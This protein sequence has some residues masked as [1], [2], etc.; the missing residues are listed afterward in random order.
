[1]PPLPDSSVPPLFFFNAAEERI[2]EPLATQI[3]LLVSSLS[4]VIAQQAGPQLLEVASRLSALCLDS[5]RDGSDHRAEA[6][7]LISEL[8]LES[9]NTL[10]RSFT[11][12]FHLI[13]Q[14]EKQEIVRINR[15]RARESTLDAP[16]SESIEEAVRHLKSEG[17]S[18]P[19]VEELLARI[20]IQP[21]FTAHPTEARRRSILFKQQA[22]AA[23]LSKLQVCELTPGEAEDALSDIHHQISLLFATDEVRSS[24][25]RV[26]TEVE[27]GLYFIR[28]SVWETIPRIQQDI[29]R[30][31]RRHFGTD[32][33]Q[34]PVVRM[35]SW[36]GSDRDGNPFVTPDVTLRTAEVHR[37]TALE[38]YLAE[39][40]LLR[41][42]LSVS[43]RQ[44][45]IP[46]SL[47][48]S[49][50]RDADRIQLPAIVVELYAH[51]P[52]RLKISYMM[53]RI[54]H[55]LGE[56]IIAEGARS[57]PEAVYT[58]D[59]FVTDLELLRQGLGESGIGDLVNASRLVEML[60]RAR[61]FGFHLAALDVRQHSGILRQAV[62]ALLKEAGVTEGYSDLPEAEKRELLTRELQNRRPLLSS[63][64]RLPEAA[65]DVLETFRVIDELVHRDPASIGSFIVSMTH[66]VSN[67]LEVMLL[68]KEV[69]LW[70]LVA[71]KVETALDVV[72][73]FETIDDLAGADQFM[74]D[75][76][77][78]PIYRL[79]LDARSNLQE[80]MLGYSDSNKDGGFY[81]AN[82]ALYRAQNSLGAICRKHAVDFRLFHGRGGTVGR[83]G[84]RANQA[85]MAMPLSS[86]SG[87]IRFT[88]QGEVISFRYSLVDIAHRH[89]EQIVNAT[90]LATAAATKGESDTFRPDEQDVRLMEALATTSMAAYR[91]L[92]TDEKLWFWY[93][94]ITPIEHISRLPIASR[95]VS[96]KSSEEV[97]FASLRAIPWVFSWTQVRYIVPGWYGM[98]AALAMAD[99]D[100]QMSHL[101]RLYT[102]W[103]F[104][105]AV[106]DSAQR[107]MARA[108][109]EIAG[110][111]AD[112]AGSESGEAGYHEVLQ[113][114]FSLAEKSILAVTGQQALLE[115]NEVIRNSIRLRNP[116]TD[117]LNLLQIDLIRRYRA[118]PSEDVDPVRR[119]LFLSINGIA[120]A[121]QS[122]G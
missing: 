118:A 40:R 73:L 114:D 17:W 104:F 107:E 69:G 63:V 60:D 91:E 41:R 75:L 12:M 57:G 82:W 31:M 116:F 96:R 70:R 47:T 97:D 39:L 33:D 16:R 21:T 88:E 36:I 48:E 37:K 80:M 4:T 113:K 32:V 29:R 15:E 19:D 50:S 55:L 99:H 43:A 117:V 66:S 76:F 85:I 10:L 11:A 94:R 25:M 110:R 93:T 6:T 22:I 45:P 65:S 120:A 84:G 52:Y 56:D 101:Q 78:N 1:M 62:S 38:M 122:T 35:R 42:D 119:A 49:I 121:M 86:Q 9:I 28:N 81:M 105:A 26:E 23:V 92:I 112:L 5:A 67:L 109:L 2:S 74:D 89:L 51:E 111:Y 87:R 83:G 61:A 77:Q 53:A 27:H 8:D 103:P 98:G 46:P 115:N 30:A 90:I 72:P 18:A 20:D 34:R 68:G 71:G 7:E 108:R 54:R 59:A 13:N 24:G 102:S 44:A 106:I 79:H 100:P 64:S 58:A 95:P 3:N 14:S